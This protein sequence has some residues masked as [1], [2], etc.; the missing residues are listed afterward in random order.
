MFFGIQ[1]RAV[2]AIRWMAASLLLLAVSG[3]MAQ[4][5]PTRPV[6]IINPYP[7]G[8]GMDVILRMIAHELSTDWGQ[9][10]LVDNKPGAGATISAAYVARS[11]P[12]G[13]TILGTT[14]QHAVSPLLIKNLPYNFN[15]SFSP[16][17]LLGESPYILIV[18]PGLNVET[19]PQLVE[20]IKSKGA[21]MNFGSP[22][23]GALPHLAG[24]LLNKLTGATVTHIPFQGTAPALTALLGG[25]IDYMFTDVSVLQTVLAGKVKALA[26]TTDKRVP[27][28]P[29]APAMTEYYPRFTFVVWAGLEAA[30]GTPAAVI[31]KMNASVKKAVLSEAFAKRLADVST[32][33]RASSPE[34]FT[35]FKEDEYKKYEQLVKEAGVKAE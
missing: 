11:A 21:T 18:R 25:Q 14:S 23:N 33:P 35:K 27:Q 3:A 20:L 4:S 13:Y 26:V 2:R 10:V 31:Q 8:G 1:A 9:P 22:G 12:D 6:T 15:R 29:N 24:V 32:T 17:S 5:Y 19:V 7:P 34:E 28:L 16:I 30:A